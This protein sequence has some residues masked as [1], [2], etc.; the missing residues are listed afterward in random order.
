[1]DAPKLMFDFT[2]GTAAYAGKSFRFPPLG[3]VTQDLVV[4]GGIRNLTRKRLASGGGF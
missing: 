2:T 3:A 1:M 4:A